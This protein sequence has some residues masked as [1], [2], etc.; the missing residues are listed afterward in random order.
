MTSVLP[1]RIVAP[2]RAFAE[3]HDANDAG[4]LDP[5]RFLKAVMAP[6]D[7]EDVFPGIRTTMSRWEYCVLHYFA[8]EFHDAVLS[9]VLHSLSRNMRGFH[10]S[11]MYRH[12]TL[13]YM[14]IGLGPGSRSNLKRN[15]RDYPA[16]FRN[17]Y[18]SFS[19]DGVPIGERHASAFKRFAKALFQHGRNEHRVLEKGSRAYS[20]I[21]RNAA[22]AMWQVLGCLALKKEYRPP[23]AL[24]NNLPK[25][26]QRF[27]DDLELILKHPGAHKDHPAFWRLALASAATK[28]LYGFK[29]TDEEGA[30]A[31]EMEFAQFVLKF[32]QMLR[33]HNRSPELVDAIA[34]I[35]GSLTKGHV[36][37]QPP[38]QHVYEVGDRKLIIQ[39]FR[40]PTWL[41]LCRQ[42]QSAEGDRL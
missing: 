6:Y 25:K 38:L 41:K 9:N 1:R 4:I 8:D 33:R 42:V 2:K 17:Y 31:I 14:R 32:L 10:E 30:G 11:K 13:R 5:N 35:R 28:V 27:T 29:F 26:A 22:H 21:R 7:W 34:A 16:I 19:E 24:R 15:S 20:L 12:T 36:H 23:L 39:N 18:G 3:H 40:F 37:Y